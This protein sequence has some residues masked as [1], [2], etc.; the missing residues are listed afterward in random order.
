[1]RGFLERDP[2]VRLGCKKN[3]DEALKDIQEHPFFK[4]KLDW[5]KVGESVLKAVER[6]FLSWKPAKSL[7]PTFLPLR[8]IEIFSTST[9]NSR[10]R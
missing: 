7:L 5:D 4:E 9:M 10:V 2:A 8:M 1:M 3:L 6:V